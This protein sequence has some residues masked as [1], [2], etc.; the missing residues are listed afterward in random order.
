MTEKGMNILEKYK[1]EDLAE[2]YDLEPGIEE[3]PAV[4]S[5]LTDAELAEVEFYSQL[6]AGVMVITGEPG[7]GKETFMHF[8]LWKLKTLFKDYRILLD[9][10]PRIRFGS[11][12]PFNEEILMDEFKGMSDRYRSGKSDLKR[13]FARYSK[14]KEI[15][16]Q[17]VDTWREN[18]DDLFYN[19]GI[20]LAEFWRYFYNREPHNPMN[21]TVAPLLR[22]YRHW[23]LLVI[24]T[25]PDIDEL[26]E[27]SCLRRLTHEVRAQQTTEKGV[28]VYTIYRRRQFAGRSMIEV[29]VDPIM[30]VVNAAAPRKRLGG[31][32]IYDLFNS[33]ERGESVPRVKY[34]D[35][36][37][38]DNNEKGGE[39]DG[40]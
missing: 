33:Y 9:R 18:N 20:G 24:G 22:R 30:L 40:D 2:L 38:E 8:L 5:D 29:A 17:I 28:H 37:D 36:K 27:K 13:D 21:K 6:K 1:P 11:Y 12:V 19:A 15:I 26:D 3:A 7:S 32:C 10:K 14:K 4:N 16:N 39:D 35:Y 34:A 23:N 25:T 31:G